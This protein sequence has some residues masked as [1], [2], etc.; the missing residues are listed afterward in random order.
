MT[1]HRNRQD[2]VWT[3]A[4]MW[5]CS[6]HHTKCH[7]FFFVKQIFVHGIGYVIWDRQSQLLSLASMRRWRHQQWHGSPTWNE[8]S[9]YMF[10]YLPWKD[11]MNE[12]KAE[13]K[14]TWT[15][16]AAVFFWWSKQRGIKLLNVLLVYT[17]IARNCVV[18]CVAVVA[19]ESDGQNNTKQCFPSDVCWILLV[20][21]CL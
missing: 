5:C 6:F 4:S 11:A 15:M 17:F 8:L 13:Q 2:D 14:K 7:V 21:K 19:V 9:R 1:Y 3:C 18:T 10:Q 16:K 20:Y 12:C